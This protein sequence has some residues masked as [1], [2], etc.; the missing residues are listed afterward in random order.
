LGNIP[1]KNS[2]RSTPDSNALPKSRTEA[3]MRLLQIVAYTV[4]EKGM[5]FKGVSFGKTIMQALKHLWLVKLRHVSGRSNDEQRRYQA[6][7]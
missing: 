1:N 7:V 6:I 4:V 5:V 2:V 3:I